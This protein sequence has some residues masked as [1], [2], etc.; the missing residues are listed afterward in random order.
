MVTATGGFTCA[1]ALAK[2]RHDIAD[3]ADYVSRDEIL[4]EERQM[5]DA[6]V[7]R[8][9]MVESQIRTS[10]VTDRRI[11]RAMQDIPREAFVAPQAGAIAYMDDDVPVSAPGGRAMM[12]PRV[13]ARLLQL[14]AP[15]AGDTA[16]VVG[17]ATGYT[18]AILA[19][20]VR[21]VVALEQDEGLAARAVERMKA[22]AIDTVDVVTGSLAAGHEGAAP[23]DVIVL[24]GSVDETPDALLRQLAPTG[25]MVAIVREGG[26]GR[27]M[28]WRRLPE[29]YSASPAFDAGAP[30]L[31]GFARAPA[32]VL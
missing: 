12:A 23:Y 3:R 15:E 24:D 19:R 21:R 25:R 32:F 10:D 11:V 13:L 8:R 27:A 1:S 31:P 29:G 30:P 18:A 2:V 6:D 26:V 22:L 7:Q 17:A 4:T 9:N 14:A 28:L 20:I 5:V 16:L